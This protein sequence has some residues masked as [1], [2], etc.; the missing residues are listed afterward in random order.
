[1]TQNNPQ[2]IVFT[3]A[4]F[5][6]KST[7]LLAAID[8]YTYQRRRVLCFKPLMDDRYGDTEIVTHSGKRVPA[9]TVSNGD[10]I[11]ARI[12]TEHDVDVI[13]VDEAFMIDGSADALIH[14]FKLGYTVIVS[15]LEMSAS[16]TEF[17]EITKLMVWATKIEKL[18]AVCSVC[19][20]DAYYTRRKSEGMNEIQVGGADMYEPRCWE[21]HELTNLR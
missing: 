4:M 1:M 18:P 2:L 21:H 17:S 5:S 14:L 8:R 7:H 9:V 6:G 20:R 19:Q 3:G 12:S 16:C 13:A 11:L 15:S 10:D